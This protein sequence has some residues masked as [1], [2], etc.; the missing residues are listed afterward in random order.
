MN[1]LIYHELNCLW[2][3]PRLTALDATERKG[4]G[5]D[6]SASCWERRLLDNYYLHPPVR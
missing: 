4:Y 5:M 3:V 6:H 2:S 1:A